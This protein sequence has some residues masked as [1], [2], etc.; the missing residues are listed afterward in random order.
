MS[1]SPLHWFE[2]ETGCSVPGPEGWI[3]GFVGCPLIE[4]KI[5]FQLG[6]HQLIQGFF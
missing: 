1:T 6:S 5:D 3:E 2:M 4:K